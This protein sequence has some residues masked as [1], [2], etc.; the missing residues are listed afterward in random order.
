MDNSMGETGGYPL[1]ITRWLEATERACEGG[2]GWGCHE[3]VLGLVEAITCYLG[4]VAVGQ[5][6]QALYREQIEADPALNRSLRSLR[7][8]LPGQWLRW[9]SGGLAAVGAGQVAGLSEWYTR[10]Q[11]GRMAE[12]YTGLRNVMVENLGYAG[13]YGP[14]DS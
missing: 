4:A 12:A 13:D 14:R 10:E 2:E 6:S 8:V 5:Y 11:T 3:A 9:A 1:P 7:R